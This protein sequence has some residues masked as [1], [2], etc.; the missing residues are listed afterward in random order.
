MYKVF[1]SMGLKGR[2][3]E[4]VTA[5]LTRAQKWIFEN[6]VDDRYDDVYV[7]DNLDCSTPE[8]GGRL[9]CLG[10]AI[11]KLGDCDACFFVK[12][13]E[14]YNGCRAEMKIC[15]LYGIRTIIET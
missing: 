7:I 13:W 14:N 15:N 11:K 1:V 4:E 9:W 6:L 2:N 8:D 5:D 12:G 3:F 10:E